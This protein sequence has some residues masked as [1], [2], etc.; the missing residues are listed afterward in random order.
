MPLATAFCFEIAR[1]HQLQ[2]DIAERPP[3]TARELQILLKLRQESLQ[4]ACKIGALFGID[5]LSAKRFGS[6]EPPKEQDFFEEFG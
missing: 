4:N 6:P 2:K 1:Y 3:R 5:P